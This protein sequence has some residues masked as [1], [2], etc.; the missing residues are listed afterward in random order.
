MGDLSLA[1]LTKDDLIGNVHVAE[2]FF[3]DLICQ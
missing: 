1:E 2:L 3:F